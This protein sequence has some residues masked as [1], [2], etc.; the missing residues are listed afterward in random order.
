MG[1]ADRLRPDMIA[2]PSRPRRKSKPAHNT[3]SGQ[4]SDPKPNDSNSRARRVSRRQRDRQRALALLASCPDGCPEALMIAHG[5]TIEDMV[6]LVHDGLATATAE[7]VRAGRETLEVA[8]V[9]ITDAGRSPGWYRSRVCRGPRFRL[10]HCLRRM[11]SAS[12]SQH[13]S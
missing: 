12:S 5:F 3:D 13:R 10:R 7:R 2:K 6:A 8:R 1:G 9:R 11:R 4:V